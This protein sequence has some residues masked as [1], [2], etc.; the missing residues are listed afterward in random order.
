M[1]IRGSHYLLFCVLG[2]G[3]RIFGAVKERYWLIPGLISWRVFR[4]VHGVLWLDSLGWRRLT[5]Y[6]CL[7]SRVIS[8]IIQIVLVC[9]V[10]RRLLPDN[11]GNW[12]KF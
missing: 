11:L 10:L 2:V 7:H 8:S 5:F 1:S 9:N 3:R 6:I 4:G 12:W